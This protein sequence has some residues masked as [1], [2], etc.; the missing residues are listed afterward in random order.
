M[1]AQDSRRGATELA[2]NE[3]GLEAQIEALEQEL[4]Q[5]H[6]RI[7]R[8]V[9]ALD[10]LLGDPSTPARTASVVRDV[11]EPAAVALGAGAARVSELVGIAAAAETAPTSLA[12]VL[13]TA[14]CAAMFGRSGTVTLDV[15]E[16]PDVF[17][18]LGPM[19]DALAGLLACMLEH[20]DR[21]WVQARAQRRRVV[22]TIRAP[23]AVPDHVVQSAVGRL[24]DATVSIGLGLVRVQR[25]SD[26]PRVHL[27]L[28]T[29]DVRAA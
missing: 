27:E 21:L 9:C 5:A 24:R 25:E 7:D 16:L 11:I 2:A 8:V 15:P 18:E 13:N 14:G 17:G 6:A 20:A 3:V 23:A 26:G 10:T 1:T 4:R 19:Q 22:I 12:K 28:P 29:A